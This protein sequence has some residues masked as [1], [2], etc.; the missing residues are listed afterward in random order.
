MG[1]ASMPRNERF[2]RYSRALALAAVLGVLLVTGATACGVSASRSPVDHGAG[3]KAD[4]SAND[5]VRSVPQPNEARS[6]D[7]LVRLF[8]KAPVGGSESA[9]GQVKTFLT[10]K[11]LAD[12]KEPTDPQSRQLTVIRIVRGPPPGVPTGER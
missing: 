1:G 7:A 6:P 11:A 10:P 8:L 9:I 4:T 3:L 2:T 12:W 5:A